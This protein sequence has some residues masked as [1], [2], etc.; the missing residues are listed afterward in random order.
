M[1]SVDVVIFA[2]QV[3]PKQ[4]TR[5]SIDVF[6]STL[7][8]SR[9]L[10]F[11]QLRQYFYMLV[12]EIMNKDVK[13]IE[14][15]ESVQEAAAKMSRHSIGSLI[16]IKGGSLQGIITERDILSKVVAKSLDA[17][18]T[19]VS[20]IMTKAVVMISPD[21]DIEDAAE[22]MVEKDIKKLPV[23]KGDKLIGIV[24]SMDIVV[25]QPKLMKQMAAL[26][27]MSRGK[28]AVAG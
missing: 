11:N 23:L 7:I 28:K 10:L 4:A 9:T 21:R 5:G 18:S 19:K 22:V 15:D 16:V 14:P 17:S 25:A 26:F 20:N 12:R 8:W 13:T 3:L 1:P 6:L 27:L 24:T 2:L